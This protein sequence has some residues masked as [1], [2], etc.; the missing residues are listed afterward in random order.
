MFYA[1]SFQISAYVVDIIPQLE[2]KD[3][4]TA[5][6]LLST[7]I[8]GLISLMVFS[9]SMVMVVLNQASSNFSPRLL[10]GLI[11]NKNHQYVLGIY[12][13]TIIYCILIFISVESGE[14][15][16]MLPIFSI[17]VAIIFTVWCLGLFIYFIHSISQS[18]QVNN[19][20]RTIYTTACNRL[21]ILLD[22]KEPN[23]VQHNNISWHHFTTES[24]GYYAGINKRSFSRI[25]KDKEDVQL[26]V[27]VYKGQFVKP[28]VEV[29]KTNVTLTEAEQK[30]FTSCLTFTDGEIVEENYA[31]AFKQLTE[32]AVKAMSPG[33]NDP[34][35]AILCI[36]YLSL[37]LRLR[38]R[39]TDDPLLEKCG[40]HML[41]NEVVSFKNILSVMLLELRRYCTEDT[42][43]V[44]KLIH[45]L[46]YLMQQPK[47]CPSYHE[48]I[49]TELAILKADALNNITS[50]NDRNTVRAL[51]TN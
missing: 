36:D 29:F 10:P 50:E 31:L 51:F 28:G 11:S 14:K 38:M 41:Y 37:L 21:S 49:K 23:P 1:E 15:E 12:L 13:A 48:T 19:I 17:L 18:I 24:V 45:M 30:E 47:A 4:D 34:G 20:V 9:F 16:N 5:Q 39:L 44:I 22:D 27:T 26:Y 7:I 40:N 8:G 6:T 35:T 33:I 46:Q 42:A 3:S 2:I 43:L 32:I 25:F